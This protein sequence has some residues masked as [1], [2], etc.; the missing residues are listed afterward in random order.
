MPSSGSFSGPT[1]VAR[2]RG[3]R[4][5]ASTAKNES[6][7]NEAPQLGVSHHY[8][9]I[10]LGVGI[11]MEAIPVVCEIPKLLNIGHGHYRTPLVKPGL[12]SITE[13]SEKAAGRI[14]GR[15]GHSAEI[16]ESRAYVHSDV[17]QVAGCAGPQ[18]G[19]QLRVFSASLRSRGKRSISL[20]LCRDDERVRTSC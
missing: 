20:R 13:V 2:Q 6:P 12:A 7:L 9:E 18:V 16:F 1:S 3:I 17:T 11:M 4:S 5:L 15:V 14:I 8:R 10:A 19:A